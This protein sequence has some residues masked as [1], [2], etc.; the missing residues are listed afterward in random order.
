MVLRATG[1]PQLARASTSAAIAEFA[2]SFSDRRSDR[3][4]GGDQELEAAGNGLSA[5][6]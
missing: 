3:L 6:Q 4:I 5:A 2:G 1:L